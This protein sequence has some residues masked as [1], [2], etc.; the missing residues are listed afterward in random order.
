ML[1]NTI[2]LHCR[3]KRF[4]VFS[5]QIIIF[6]AKYHGLITKEGYEKRRVMNS[7]P[8]TDFPF[9]ATERK[10]P[11]ILLH[12]FSKLCYYFSKNYVN[13]NILQRVNK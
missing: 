12:Y 13:S 11:V 1:R 8:Q 10:C 7:F 6:L 3:E 4:Q 5:D 9:K 2:L